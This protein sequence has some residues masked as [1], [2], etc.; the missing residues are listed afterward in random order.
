MRHNVTP[1]NGKNEL[2]AFAK[3]MFGNYLL[4]NNVGV[5]F[6]TA[7]SN[8]TKHVVGMI[9]CPTDRNKACTIHCEIVAVVISSIIVVV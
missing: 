7:K 1:I 4:G 3:L 2:L 9:P 6:C 8:P 5:L